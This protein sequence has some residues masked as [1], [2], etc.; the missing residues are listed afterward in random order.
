[1]GVDS[2]ASEAKWEGPKRKAKMRDRARSI[3]KLLFLLGEYPSKLF[4]V[5]ILKFLC[6]FLAR[7]ATP[8]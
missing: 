4:P 6:Y 1:M 3:D 8:L 2:V 7:K 5:E